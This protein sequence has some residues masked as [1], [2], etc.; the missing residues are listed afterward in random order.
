MKYVFPLA[1]VLMVLGAVRFSRAASPLPSVAQ[2]SA[3]ADTLAK[4]TF[5]GGCFWCMEQA[6]D[7]LTGV[8]S[9]TSGYTGGRTENPTYEQVSSGGTGHAEVIQVA[10]DPRKIGYPA[11]LDAFWHNID[12]LTP[13]AQF[14]DHGP[15]YRSAVFYH[16]DEQ[17]EQVEASKRKLEQSGRFKQPIVTE[18]VKA[19]TFYPAEEY[20]QDYY[21]KNPV[22]YK[23]YKWNCGRT[24]RLK[25]VWG[26]DAAASTPATNP[27]PAVARVKTND[28][29]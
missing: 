8:A 17:R 20:H 1:L 25:K 18:I 12:P 16:T 5:A 21:R 2:S 28:G 13:N 4:A 19:S 23:F 22:R 14:C 9:V 24:A 10:Y 27:Q 7:P 6:F 3:P 11:L 15:Q 29:A 26:N